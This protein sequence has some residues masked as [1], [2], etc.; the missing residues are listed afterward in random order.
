[1]T[2]PAAPGGSAVPGEVAVLAPFVDAGVFGPYETHLAAAVVRLEPGVN[3]EA[4]VALAAAARATRFGHVCVELAEVARQIVPIGDSGEPGEDA[5]SVE[6]EALPWPPA[7]AWARCLSESGIVSSPGDAPARLR[8]LVFDGRFLYLQRYWQ[9][10]L[11][12]AED[13]PGRV[14]RAR[15]EPDPVSPTLADALSAQV[16]DALFEPDGPD[17]VDLQRLAARRA[18]GSGVSII[19]GGPGTGKTHTVA[20]VLAAAHL[21]AAA[22]GREL[23]AALAAPTG[24]AAVRMEGAV[25]AEVTALSDS[26]L[27]TPELA[28][29]LTGPGAVTLHR[30]LGWRPGTHFRHDRGHPLPH[31]LVIVDETSM[32]SLPLMAKLLDAV[33]PDAQLVLVGDPFQ[34]ASIEAGTVMADLVGPGAD[35]GPGEDTDPAGEAEPASGSP[36]AGRVTLLR[37]MHRFAE[38]SGIAALAEAIRAGEADVALD[39]LAG[40][41]PDAH[42]V[43]DDDAEGL[44]R[45][46][47]SVAVAGVEMAS[48]AM[49]GD[50][51]AALDGAHRIKVLAA[52]R[53]GPLG[54]YDWSDRMAAAVAD[55]LPGV[56]RSRA[57]YAGRPVMV[58]A[59]DPVN[60]VF[61][62]DVG[63]VVA[64]VSGEPMVAF[65]GVDGLRYLA[66]SRLGDVETWWAMTIHKSQGSEFPHAVVSLPRS[67]SPVLTR[68]LLYTAVTRAKEQVTLVGSEASIRAAIGRPVARASGLRARLWPSPVD[69]IPSG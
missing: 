23:K 4:V 30:L 10:E 1:M 55:A 45:V 11:A 69:S 61:N 54:V 42:W 64:T 2:P 22:D 67:A 25:I 28:A 37:R 31:D 6:A 8:P 56:S 47:R 32:V 49:G 34:L 51:A 48:A 7:E 41:S 53:R 35:A 21:I 9:Y 62:G 27:I 3:D 50:A 18:L 44:D 26:G 46:R 63:V 12:V 29:R 43:R 33:R 15:P 58:T 24:K 14:D 5:V 40:G 39:L 17:R 16:L 52:T 65:T 66:P 13:L 20:R 57:W 68:E 59:N 38:G 60:D 19:A 36:L